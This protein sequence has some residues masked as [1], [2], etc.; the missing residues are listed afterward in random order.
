MKDTGMVMGSVCVCGGGGGGDGDEDE[1]GGIDTKIVGV[2]SSQNWG[3]ES[4]RRWL[5]WRRECS[6]PQLLA[7]TPVRF[8]RGVPLFCWPTLIELILYPT[9]GSAPRRSPRALPFHPKKKR[10]G[11]GGGGKRIG[12]EGVCKLFLGVL[13]WE[14]GASPPECVDRQHRVSFP[15]HFALNAVGHLS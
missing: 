6:T 7:A 13:Y 1:I 9:T 11:G 14:E 5:P 3:R 8:G 12:E 2:K 10:G 4:S 15:P